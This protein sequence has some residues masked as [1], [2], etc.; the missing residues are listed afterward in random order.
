MDRQRVDFP[1]PE[2][3]ETMNNIPSFFFINVSPQR[4][5]KNRDKK[6]IG[7]Q[8]NFTAEGTEKEPYGNES[9]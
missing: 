4:H 5:R 8:K 7:E 3:P 2:A 1:V 6:K 9:L